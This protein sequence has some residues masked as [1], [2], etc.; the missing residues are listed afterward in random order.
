M[1]RDNLIRSYFSLG[2]H[3]SE[4]LSLLLIQHNIILSERQLKRILRRLN[5]TR[6]KN[7]S[8]FEEI[9]LFIEELLE[10]SGRF[11]GYRWIHLKCLQRG[12]V[13]KQETVR[14]LLKILDPT[15]VST[16]RRRRLRRRDYFNKGPNYLWHMDGYDKLKP[17]GIA[18]SGC[19]DGFS[20]Y[21][22]WLQASYTNNNPRIISG[23]YISA[24]ES[25][26]GCPRSVRSDLGTENRH[27]EQMQI[28][29][30]NNLESDDSLPPFIYGSSTH[31]QRIEAWW[32][33]LRKH[34]AQFWMDIFEDLKNEGKFSGTILDKALVQYCFLHLV[35]GQLDQVV[36]E[37]N[38]H[39]IS[40]R[41]RRS[42]VGKPIIMYYTPEMYYA[43]DYIVKSPEDAI[44]S[45]REESLFPLVHCDQDVYE[46]CQILSEENHYERPSTAYEATDLYIQLRNDILSML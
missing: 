12:L 28:F 5:L 41:N 8:S 26:G 30:R 32:G 13:V 6:R 27:V 2:L 7:F 21:I 10:G 36:Q 23:Y 9:F 14:L 33:I 24:V 15:G 29:L 1:E 42:P 31:N 34:N 45:C 19:I 17:Y 44:L 22:I 4:I 18:I 35:Q 11:H 43:R 38:S 37:W 46:L 40:S 25:C 3:Y 39:K 20:R 16:R